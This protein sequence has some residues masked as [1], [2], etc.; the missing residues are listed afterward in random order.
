MDVFRVQAA[1]PLSAPLQGRVEVGGAKNSAL[2][3]MAATLLAS[4]ESTITN[5]PQ[6]LDVTYMGDLLDHLG[7]RVAI[8][9]DRAV[10]DVP[11]RIGHEAPYE[12]VRRLRASIAVLG[13]L[14]AR[15]GRASVP[16]PGGDAIGSRG[17]HMHLAGLEALGAQVRMEHGQVIA[18]APGGLRATQIELP[19][20]SVGATENLVTASVLARGTTEID[21]V[22]REPEIIDLCQMLVS[23]GA[24][25]D[26]IGSPTLTVEGVDELHPVEHATVGD[27]IVGGVV[28]FTNPSAASTAAAGPR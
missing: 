24:R 11:E 9:D 7:C 8:E 12:L 22:A 26:G 13:P 5:V 20:P 27:R 23:M 15:C 3:L 10:I 16:M 14:V 19:F 28:Q 17:L 1:G 6:I 25:I 2:K 18:E 21:N 4:G